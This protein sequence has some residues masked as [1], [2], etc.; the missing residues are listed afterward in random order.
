[1]GRE[2]LYRIREEVLTRIY[3]ILLSSNELSNKKIRRRILREIARDIQKHMEGNIGWTYVI[4]VKD[5]ASKRLIEKGI[6]K[7]IYMYSKWIKYSPFFAL[8]IPPPIGGIIGYVLDEK[9]DLYPELS[10]E[11]VASGYAFISY[12]LGG[13]FAVF[14]LPYLF[15][16]VDLKWLKKEFRLKIYTKEESKKS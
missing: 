13:V 2:E 5:E 7:G 8:L 15:D 12:I 16:D 10:P 6:N 11:A 3:E 4:E 14:L 9:F 1:M